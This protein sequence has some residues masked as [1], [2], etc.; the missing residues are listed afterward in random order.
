M[1]RI[2]KSTATFSSRFEFDS[3]VDEIAA[4]Q[5]KI[6]SSIADHNEQKAAQDKAFKTILARRKGKLT[7]LL[8]QAN[9]YADI[10]R[11][12]L[13][14]EKQTA[15]TKLAEYGYRKSPG[16]IKTLNS[17]WTFAKAKDAL[18]AAGQTMCIKVTETLN[19]PA[20]KTE[21]PEADLPKYGLR[22]DYPEEFWIE[23]KRAEESTDKRLKS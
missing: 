9:V 19:K 14:G 7:S 18:K 20:V 15:E 10:N 13:L 16:I 11:D 22:M 5:L 8:S 17:R 4:L 12:Q 6:D 1:P 21:I 3:C 2:K 23:A